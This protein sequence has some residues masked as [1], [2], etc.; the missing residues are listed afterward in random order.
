METIGDIKIIRYCGTEDAD[1]VKKLTV[2]LKPHFEHE[3]FAFVGGSV[4]NDKPT[5]TL[6]FTTPMTDAGFHAGNIIRQSAKVI[7]GGG[8]GQNF[9]A[10]AGGKKAENIQQAIEETV[11]L[12]TE[13]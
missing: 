4:F 6:F 7:E 12:I 13:K 10:S 11:K 5:L 3:K 2:M 1:F 8:G 9:L